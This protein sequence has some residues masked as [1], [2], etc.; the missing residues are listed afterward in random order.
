MTMINQFGRYSG[1]SLQDPKLRRLIDVTD[2][3]TN[4]SVQVIWTDS[5]DE[6]PDRILDVCNIYA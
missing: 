4:I 2:A 6:I 3:F 1:L 5:F